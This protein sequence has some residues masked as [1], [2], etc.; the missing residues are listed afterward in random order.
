MNKRARAFIFISALFVCC[1][2]SGC[3][4]AYTGSGL[5]EE[6]TSPG[7]GEEKIILSADSV[8]ISEE[9]YEKIKALKAFL[10]DALIDNP[11]TDE[12]EKLR[13]EARE[14]IGDEWLARKGWEYY[15][16]CV[17]IIL[18]NYEKN[19]VE[20]P[21]FL[22]Y[23][24][25]DRK[26]GYFIYLSGDTLEW[27]K[28]E[29]EQLEF[30]GYMSTNLEWMKTDSGKKYIW[31]KADY[32]T[33]CF[34]GEDNIAYGDEGEE[35]PGDLIEIEGDYYGKFDGNQIGFSIEE[36]TN[37]ANCIKLTLSGGK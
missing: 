26:N 23:M 28:L 32:F 34:I 7:L 27:N 8:S 24:F 25:D 31:T 20:Y 15:L 21:E 17:P 30:H 18:W 29:L 1:L 10:R 5:S 2:F 3:G 11:D 16:S 9:N 35:E 36:L 13:K 4:G 6:S 12:I 37:P 19:R 33:N 14:C 22:L